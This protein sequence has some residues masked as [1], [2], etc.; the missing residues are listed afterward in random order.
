M[1]KFQKYSISLLSV[2]ALFGMFRGIRMIVS[3]A[4]ESLLL[5]YPQ[6]MIAASVFTNYSILGWI[7]FFLVGILSLIAIIVT[8]KHKRNFAY[9]IIVEGIFLSFFTLS[10]MLYSGFHPVHLFVMPLGIGILVLGVIQTPRE[11]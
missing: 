6:D 9:F 1:T 3:P 2:P 5:P 8:I 7:I 10:H 4:E 11:F